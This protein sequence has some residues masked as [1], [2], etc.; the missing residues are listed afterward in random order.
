[1]TATTTA[2][3]VAERLDAFAAAW[4]VL[5]R[6]L[7]APPDEDVLAALSEPGLLDEWPLHRDGPTTLGLRELRSSLLTE[8]LPELRR[9]Y[10]ALFVGP[11]HMLATPYE[12]VY[13][14]EEHLIFD[15]ATRQVRADYARAGLVNTALGR[16]PD[17]H[18]GLEFAFLAHLCTQALDEWEDGRPIDRTLRRYH[19]FLDDHVRVWLPTLLNSITRGARTQFYR[20]VADLALGALDQSAPWR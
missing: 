4:T 14:S 9:D 3:P 18:V 7:L 13:R 8:S 15:E 11:G 1:M 5:S 19:C 12:S 16:E 10:D 17:D 6:L 2:A 20:A